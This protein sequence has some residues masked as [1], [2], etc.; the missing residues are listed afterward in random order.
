[1]IQAISNK[2]TTIHVNNIL[3]SVFEKANSLIWSYKNLEVHSVLNIKG[4]SVETPTLMKTKGI[5]DEYSMLSKR[6]TLLSALCHCFCA[7][8]RKLLPGYHPSIF[9]DKTGGLGRVKIQ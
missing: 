8:Q 3:T 9:L 4:F 7:K 5:L 6:K 1:M 2:S